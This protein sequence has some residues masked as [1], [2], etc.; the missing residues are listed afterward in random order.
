MSTSIER[1]VAPST[2]H[3]V[4]AEQLRSK[5]ISV[6]QGRRSTWCQTIDRQELVSTRRGQHDP[7]ILTSEITYPPDGVAGKCTR[8]GAVSVSRWTLMDVDPQAPTAAQYR[9][10]GERARAKARSRHQDHVAEVLS[11]RGVTNAAA[12]A[13]MV[14]D[15]L[16]EWRYTD[17]GERC[18]CSCHPR[19]PDSDLHD[20]GFDCGCTRTADQRR[21]SWLRVRNEIRE[22]WQSPDGQRV[23]H[24]ELVAEAELH[25]WLTR[26]PGV[27][28]HSHGGLAPEQWRG[29][30]DGHS[31]SFR[32]RHG[33]WRI[34]VD[35]RPTEPSIGAADPLRDDGTNGHRQRDFEHGDVI[36]TGTVDADGYGTTVV[37]RAQFIV[38]TIRDHLR[39]QSCTHHLDAEKLE[40][41]AV[42]IG[43]SPSWCPA[44]GQRLLGLC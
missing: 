29:D 11:E 17:T 20:Y 21:A 37:E 43:A 6:G 5:G 27:I 41:M 25:D 40:S 1:M 2:D 34:E 36:A 13:K 44:C 10:R 38:T 24:A 23:R 12:M 39:R 33:N 4:S 9:E 18:R 15:A 22:L 30:V 16:T 28:V 32:E 19:L 31:F 7:L 35:L 26:H 8:H 14:V 3:L 42:V